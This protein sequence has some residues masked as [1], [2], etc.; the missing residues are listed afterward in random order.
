M[1]RRRAASANPDPVVRS[2]WPVARTPTGL[3]GS[4]RPR[5]APGQRIGF[6]PR[7]PGLVTELVV[8]QSQRR[9]PAPERR[10]AEQVPALAAPGGQAARERRQ[11]VVRRVR[12]PVDGREQRQRPRPTRRRGIRASRCTAVEIEVAIEMIDTGQDAMRRAIRLDAPDAA[13]GKRP[14]LLVADLVAVLAARGIEHAVGV[15][16]EQPVGLVVL[17]RL[18]SEVVAQ[19]DIEAEVIAGS[20]GPLDLRDVGLQPQEVGRLVVVPLDRRQEVA[21]VVGGHAAQPVRG[22]SWS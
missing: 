17:L 15:R 7:R 14:V 8:T 20:A 18:R 6:E 16:I 10:F 12:Q 19:S 22:K 2:C 9:D 5:R 21:G 3:G 11:H 4:G 1:D 13:R